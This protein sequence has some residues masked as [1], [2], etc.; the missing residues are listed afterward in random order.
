MT[1]NRDRRDADAGTRRR[2]MIM[3]IKQRVQDGTYVVDEQ[4]LAEVLLSRIVL[5][6]PGARTPSA[7]ARAR[8]ERRTAPPPGR[9]SHDRSA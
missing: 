3:E 6:L 5:N 9:P 8:P 1:L 2:S 7:A 4:R